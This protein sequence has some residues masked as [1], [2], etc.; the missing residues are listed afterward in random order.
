MKKDAVDAVVMAAKMRHLH[1]LQKLKGGST[2]TAA[3]LKEL[4]EHEDKT[5]GPDQ[6]AKDKKAA[7]ATE[8][9]IKT[10]KQAAEYAGVKTRTIRR[11]LAAG[12]PRTQDGHYIRNMLDFYKRNEGHEV[13]E[14]RKREASAQADYKTTKATLLEMELKLKQGRLLPREDIEKETVRKIIGVKRGLLGMVRKIA[15]RVPPRY[16]REVEL[17]AT[18]EVT[19]LINDFAGDIAAQD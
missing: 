19:S 1:L 6:K 16:R 3:E 4:A 18:E 11:W 17:I 8:Q 7:F 13:S 14:D 15:A 2:L 9:I 12:M 5:R 10:Q